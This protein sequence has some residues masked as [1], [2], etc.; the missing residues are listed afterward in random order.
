MLASD[1]W[2]LGLGEAG[3]WHG[4]CSLA[5]GHTML[6]RSDNIITT[7]LATH[8]SAFNCAKER[9]EAE[10]T[11]LYYSAA[12]SAPLLVASCSQF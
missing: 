7:I 10:I 1:W 5:T 3:A 12:V 6:L 9:T 11:A 4:W 2:W 8:E